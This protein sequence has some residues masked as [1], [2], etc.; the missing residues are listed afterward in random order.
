MVVFDLVTGTSR[1]INA[2][3]GVSQQFTDV[4]SMLLIISA[5]AIYV[6]P[7][8]RLLLIPLPSWLISSVL[9]RGRHESAVSWSQS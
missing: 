5:A 8:Y 2:L 3:L 4:S 9:L 1:A 7:L 6:E